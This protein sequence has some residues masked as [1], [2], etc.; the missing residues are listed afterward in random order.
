MTRTFLPI[1]VLALAA[2]RPDIGAPEYPNPL[3]IGSDT[4]DTGGGFL[5]GPDPWREGEARLSIGIFYENGASQTIPID[6]LT[7]H[8]YIY[9]NT[10]TLQTSS[11]RVEGLS[12][13]V[14]VHGSNTW[15]GGGVT[16]N[17][18]RDLYSWTTMH[19]WLKSSDAS[20]DGFQLGMNGGDTEARVSA[21]D[22]GFATD[23]AWHGL[24]V[25]LSD[26]TSQGANLGQVTVPLLLVAATGSQGET[27]SI[28]N[29]YFTAE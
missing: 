20:F 25:P 7:T 5:P 14:I 10:F 9:E 22:Y 16:W 26:F 8:F 29:L 6:N 27:M 21:T 28:D 11:D 12:S 1:A 24:S 15:W 2:C 19:V 3:P 13:D 18:A 17:A 4:A 23:G